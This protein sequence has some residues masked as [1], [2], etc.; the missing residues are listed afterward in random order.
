MIDLTRRTLLT[1]TVASTAAAGIS[2]APGRRARA[3]AAPAGTQAP[4]WYRYKV[5]N[6]EVTV[7]TDGVNRF[8][9]P[10][11]IVSNVKREEV[12]AALVAEHREPDVFVTPIIRSSSTP[13]KSSSS[14]TPVW[15]KRCSIRARG[16]SV[17]S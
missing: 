1:G 6:F 11:D 13:D 8:K 2:L 16:R 12:N 9:L 10:D 5:G 17:N 14:S 3:A 7:V 4:G 15:A